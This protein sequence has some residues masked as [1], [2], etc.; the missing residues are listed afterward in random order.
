VL[1][2]CYSCSLRWWD[3]VAPALN[4]RHRIVRFDLLGHGGSEK[5]AEGYDVDSQAD[6]I[7]EA[8]GELGV[9]GA[10]VVGHSLGTTVATALAQ[11]HSEL[12]DRV[13]LLGVGPD[14]SFHDLGFT[15][16]LS[17]APVIG[18]AIWR[19]TPR[20]IWKSGSGI[21]FADGFDTANG[22]EDP[23]Q[24]VDDLREM[25]FT[26]YDRWPSAS[27]DWDD[28]L[29]L[30]RRLATANVPALIILGAEDQIVDT[31]RAAPA[32]RETVPAARVVVMDGVGHSPNVEAPE[33]TAAMLERFARE[34][35]VAA[36]QATEPRRKPQS[37]RKKSGKKNKRNQKKQG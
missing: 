29:G 6:L 28:A 12:V 17:R 10:L 3:M 13:A 25:T 15:A 1:I 19:I 26:A 30:N 27:D 31:E 9:E 36:A 20:F 5:P 7:A 32:F 37:T 33:E 24:P 11:R 16:K 23:D 8:L 34:G 2:H 22:F 4:E 14:R 18:E 35:E 21:A